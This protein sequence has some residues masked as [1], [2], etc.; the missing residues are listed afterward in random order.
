MTIA[1]RSEAR[2]TAGGARSSGSAALRKLG[3]RTLIREE[4]YRMNTIAF[5]DTL[6]G[7]MR[8]GLRMLARSPMFTAAALLT[9]PFPLA[10]E[11]L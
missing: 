2:N 7:D 4:I 10:T 9:A 8:Y 1:A 11:T 6:V 3:N 5:F